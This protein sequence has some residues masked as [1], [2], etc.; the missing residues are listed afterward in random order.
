MLKALF[1][2]PVAAAAT[3]VL[4][5]EAA[6]AE[7]GEYCNLMSGPSCSGSLTCCSPGTNSGMCLSDAECSNPAIIACS[8]NSSCPG[9]FTCCSDGFCSS[10]FFGDCPGSGPPADDDDDDE[11]PEE[12]TTTTPA[13]S[14]ADDDDEETP[15]EPEP[16][17]DSSVCSFEEGECAEGLV[18][19]PWGPIF[20]IC[21]PQAHCD[22]PTIRPC[23]TGAYCPGMHTLCCD[24]GFCNDYQGVCSQPTTTTP[25]PGDST[26]TTPAPPLIGE[27]QSCDIDAEN[28]GCEGDLKC[29]TGG[30][31]YGGMCLS[32]AFCANYE[33]IPCESDANCPGRVVCCAD[34]YCA[35]P[36]IGL[37]CAVDRGTKG[38]GEV[39]QMGSGECS[40]GLICCPTDDVHG[41][42]VPLAHCQDP[43]LRPCTDGGDCVGGMNRE[44]DFTCCLTGFCSTGSGV[45]L[46][47]TTTTTPAP[48]EPTTTTPA[49]GNNTQPGQNVVVSAGPGT[50]T[51]ANVTSP[52]TTTVVQTLPPG[53]LPDSSVFDIANG[54]Y[55]DISTT[56]TF[57]P[58]VTVC[59]PSSSASDRLLHFTSG[60][61][62][63]ITSPG[64]PSGG[65]ICGVTDS[66]SP[67]TVVPL[68]GWT[69]DDDDD[70][71]DDGQAG[72]PPHRSHPPKKPNGSG[73]ASSLPNTGSGSTT[74]GGGAQL[75][76]TLAAS[77][78]AV[79]AARLLRQQ[80]AE[81]EPA[82]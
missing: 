18:C 70:D 47:P 7:Y 57:S 31:Y 71:D 1:G 72:R 35:N 40:P 13:P 59:L 58:P 32:S 36:P 4:K 10:D 29:C 6:A 75:G 67:F 9:R 79:A 81:D 16:G 5:Q 34:G 54:T 23:G 30:A 76:A 48:G 61:W 42:C 62:V 43:T 28:P 2:I 77:A 64:S 60:A 25:G 45:C 20:G 17:G 51:F 80:P 44:T 27:W 26:T 41:I 19:C 39:C 74:S 37:D 56:A 24:S 22:D 68:L 50:L 12:P 66:L 78:A 38:D 14:P 8:D 21:I 15:Q 73:S 52:G 53:T 55:Y 3:T 63:D 33:N 69:G 46:E 82:S 11:T 65:Q 49:P